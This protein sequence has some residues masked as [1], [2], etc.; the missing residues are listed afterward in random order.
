MNHPQHTDDAVIEM[1]QVTTGFGHHVVHRG[2]DLK[3]RRGEI[4]AVIGGSGSGK[5]T[6]LREMILLH[7]PS[8]GSIRVLGVPLEAISDDE[9]LAMRQRWGSCFNMAAC[10]VP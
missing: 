3:V 7:K 9:A 1:N 5:S 10:S 8:E 6:L 2:L 4:F